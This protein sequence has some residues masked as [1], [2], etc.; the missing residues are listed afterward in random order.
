VTSHADSGTD[1]SGRGR[2]LHT[3]LSIPRLEMLALPAW[4]SQ[5]CRSA[6]E[7]MGVDGHAHP[8]R[9]RQPGKS[10]RVKPGK[11]SEFAGV[12]LNVVGCLTHAIENRFHRKR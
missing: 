6:K 1:E 5:E 3:T 4:Q 10:Q 12:T 2:A 7:R 8:P 11:A 9:P